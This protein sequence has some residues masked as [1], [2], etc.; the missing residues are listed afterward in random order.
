M[1]KAV[2]GLKKGMIL[3]VMFFLLAVLILSAGC[4]IF[5]SSPDASPVDAER[6]IWHS[7]ESNVRIV[8]QDGTSGKTFLQN[9]QPIKLDSGQIRTALA[10]LEVRLPGSDKTIPVFTGSELDTL[11]PK[12]SEGLALAGSDQDVTFVI[13]GLRKALY[14]LAKQRKVTTGR[15]FYREGKLN[16][17]F[18]KMVE[19]LVKGGS[20]L[21]Y[22][23]QAQNDYRLNPLIPGSRSKSVKHSWILDENPDMQFYAEGGMYRTDWVMLDLASMAAHEALGIKPAKPVGTVSE[24]PANV[25][26]R[27]VVPQESRKVVSPAYQPPVITQVPQSG[28]AN[29][30]IEE[31]LQILNDLKNKKLITDEE[32]KKKRAEILNDL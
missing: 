23:Y 21:E 16:I 18:G 6:T 13:V 15:V 3:G 19:D 11:C 4:S 24:A 5:K 17:I 10:A 1:E 20:T 26:E 14:G 22:D 27:A 12:L 29:K 9:D 7:R 32:Y 28:K 31:R 30:T 25:H 8:K 2:T